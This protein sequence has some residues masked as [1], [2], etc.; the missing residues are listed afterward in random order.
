MTVQDYHLQKCPPLFLHTLSVAAGVIVVVLVNFA[1]IV[2]TLVEVVKSKRSF[3]FVGVGNVVVCVRMPER[4][5][6]GGTVKVDVAVSSTDS[7]VVIA[8]AKTVVVTLTISLAVNVVVGASGARRC[9][10][11]AA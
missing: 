11:P 2:M 9:R 3:V 6:G 7:V 4:T 10:A 5:V 8:G 1:P